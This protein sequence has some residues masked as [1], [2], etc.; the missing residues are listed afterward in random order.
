MFT[1]EETK[2]KTKTQTITKDNVMPKEQITEAEMKQEA[3]ERVSRID[4]ELDK[5][6]GIVDKYTDT[7]TIFGS[8][9]FEEGN[10]HYDKAR[11]VSAALGKEGYTVV[12]GGGGG[13]M[14]AGNRG[15]YES[16]GKSLGFNITLPHEQ[17]LNE[18]TTENM[19]F[20]Y[21]FTR[22]VILAYGGTGYV[23]FP[24]GYGTLDE[25]FE[26]LTLIQTRKMPMAPIVLVGKEYW[27]GLD[28]YIKEYMLKG[29]KAISVGDE[30]LYTITDDTD[31][32]VSIINTYR[33]NHY[34]RTI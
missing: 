25:F 33:D 4:A 7:V 19:P 10:E 15:A 3:Q 20:R 14:E 31:E 30:L 26:I 27:S 6:F 23:Y 21:F 11:E 28:K 5:G 18:Y 16:G 9:R 12:T 2:T 1:M 32:I 34:V 13:I 17:R 29:E 22:K 8:A 24:G